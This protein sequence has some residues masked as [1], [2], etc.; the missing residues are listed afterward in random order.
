M[1]SIDCVIFFALAEE[2]RKK[3]NSRQYASPLAVVGAGIFSGSVVWWS[4][5][6]NVPG[7]MKSSGSDEDELGDSGVGESGRM[8]IMDALSSSEY[9]E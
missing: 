1:V 4:S 7:M 8:L 9:A 5:A 6:G 3:I 2:E